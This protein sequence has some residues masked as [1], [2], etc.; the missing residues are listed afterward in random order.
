MSEK[1]KYHK[2]INGEDQISTPSKVTLNAYGLNIYEFK[3][4]I[5]STLNK[6]SWYSKFL[7]MGTLTFFN[8]IVY[9][10]YCYHDTKSQYQPF[11]EKQYYELGILL[12]FAFVSWVIYK[13]PCMKSERQKLI[14]KISKYFKEI[15][16]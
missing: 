1:K 9:W 6:E 16:S 3:I 13:I 14:D 5:G 8:I 7:W 10:G 4:L 12:I 15:S 2:I 11:I